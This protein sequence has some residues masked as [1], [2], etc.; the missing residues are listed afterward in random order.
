LQKRVSELEATLSA[1][2]FGERDGLGI[3]VS[4]DSIKKPM[5]FAQFTRSQ[6]N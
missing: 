2:E 1:I 6:K 5:T 4:D 3:G